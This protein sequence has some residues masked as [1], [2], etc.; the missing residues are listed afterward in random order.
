MKRSNW[1]LDVSLYGFLVYSAQRR[2]RINKW[3]TITPQSGGWERGVFDLNRCFCLS[4]A[5]LGYIQSAVSRVW[6]DRLL[7]RWRQSHQSHPAGNSLIH[8]NLHF[9]FLKIACY[10]SGGAESASSSRRDET[11]LHTTSAAD[12]YGNLIESAVMTSG[13]EWVVKSRVYVGRWSQ[14]I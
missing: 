1:C 5:R 10:C 6:T 13:Y 14:L 12:A 8:S 2:H 4:S 3:R 9:D 11:R 7:C